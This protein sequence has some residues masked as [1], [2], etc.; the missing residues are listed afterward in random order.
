MMLLKEDPE[1]WIN[2]LKMKGNS[3]VL[4]CFFFQCSWIALLKLSAI[5]SKIKISSFVFEIDFKI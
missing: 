5:H 4:K 3:Y 2:I 1:I